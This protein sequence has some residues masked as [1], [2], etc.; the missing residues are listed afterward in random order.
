MMKIDLTCPVEAWRVSLPGSGGTTCD[1]TLFNLSAQ[2]VASVEVRLRLLDARGEEA[3]LITHR[4]R[5]LNGV[6]GRTFRMQVPVEGFVRAAGYEVFIERVW[7]DNGSVW[8]HEK[9]NLIEYEPNNLRRSPALTQLRAIAGVTASGYPVEQGTGAMLAHLRGRLRGEDFPHE[10]G[11]FLGYPP[12]DVAGFLR[13]GGRGCKLCGPWK[14]YGD[15]EEAARRF[16]AFRRCRAALSRRV[17]Q[18]VSLAQIFPA[19]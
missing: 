3:K 18:G 14:V 11:L 19:A 15:A 13:D 1:V 9:E 2:Q 5:M 8:R 12:A 17:G 16:A 4:G 10:I 7:Y 6:P